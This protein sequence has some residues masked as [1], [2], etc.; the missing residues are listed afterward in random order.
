MKIWQDRNSE[1]YVHFVHMFEAIGSVF[2]PIIGAQLLPGRYGRTNW[3]LF[4]KVM[5]PLQ[6]Y[7]LFMGLLPL[8]VAPAHLYF[9][10][11]DKKVPKKDSE[12][13]HK[14]EQ[15]PKSKS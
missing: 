3:D 10:C 15:E 2:S 4:P 7:F 6:S 1:P 12:E 11:V 8:I 5:T 14:I 13:C 9:A